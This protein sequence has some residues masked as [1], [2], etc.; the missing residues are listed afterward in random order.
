VESDAVEYF[1]ESLDATLR[2]GIARLLTRFVREKVAP[3]WP[4]ESS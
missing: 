2:T 4:N 1:L 3:R